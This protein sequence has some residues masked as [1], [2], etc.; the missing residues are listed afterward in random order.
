MSN[1]A[2]A[3]EQGLS[4]IEAA[5]VEA[6]AEFEAIRHASPNWASRPA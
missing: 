2:E 6:R 3:I 5:R 4:V 1:L